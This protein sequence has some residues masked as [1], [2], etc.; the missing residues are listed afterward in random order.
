MF[1]VLQ[2][3][4]AMGFLSKED[5]MRKINAWRE[6]FDKDMN[7]SNK[8]KMIPISLNT[9]DEE[10]LSDLITKGDLYKNFVMDNNMQKNGKFFTA[11]KIFEYP[12]RVMSIRILLVSFYKSKIKQKADDKHIYQITD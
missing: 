10:K 4:E 1:M 6:M 11:V 12:N 7:A 9:Y 5:Y 8:Y 2:E 3:M